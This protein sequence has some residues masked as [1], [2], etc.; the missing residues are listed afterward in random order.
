MA[1]SSCERCIMC[2]MS[3][4]N[5]EEFWAALSLLSSMWFF[6][7]NSWLLMQGLLMGMMLVSLMVGWHSAS[8][9]AASSLPP[10]SLLLLACHIQFIML[11]LLPT[12]PLS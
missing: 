12:W 1:P 7:S 10:P 6:S 9:T 3:R 11:T 2:C 8:I 4:G 5:L